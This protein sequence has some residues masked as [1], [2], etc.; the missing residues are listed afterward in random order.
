MDTDILDIQDRRINML[1]TV[2]LTIIIS[3]V[4]LSALF[5]F[6]SCRLAKEADEKKF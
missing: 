1:K 4:I 3:I 6:G 5:I 2:L